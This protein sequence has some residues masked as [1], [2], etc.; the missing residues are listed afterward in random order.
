MR[1]KRTVLLKLNICFLGDIS[2]YKE[3]SLWQED[4]RDEV[5]KW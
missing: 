3:S 1:V 4:E 5:E 2:V